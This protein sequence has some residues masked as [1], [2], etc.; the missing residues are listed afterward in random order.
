[1]A[2]FPGDSPL[3]DHR[4]PGVISTTGTECMNGLNITCGNALSTAGAWPANNMALY[5]PFIV[6]DPITVTQIAVEVTT[7]S[8]NLDLG[9][10]SE[11]LTKL[12]GLGST[13]VGAAGVQVG[14]I[15]DTTLGPGLHYLAMCCST[16]AAAFRRANL[17]ALALRMSGAA[18]EAV[19]AVT[20]PTTATFAAHAQS[21]PFAISASFSSATM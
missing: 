11:A 20:L 4:I 21:G 17:P 1:M 5:Y 16:T 19:G 3:L 12:V 7:Q 2:D 14:N 15:A 8:G 10:Y 9:I 13:A 6:Q 18:Q